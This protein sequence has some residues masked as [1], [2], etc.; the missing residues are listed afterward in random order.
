LIKIV[1]L[2]RNLNQN[3]PKTERALG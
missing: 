1:L 3:V 2:S